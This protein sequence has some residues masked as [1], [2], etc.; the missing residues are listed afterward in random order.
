[1]KHP[2]DQPTIGLI[3]CKKRDRV[4]A[5]YALRDITKPIGLAEWQTKLVKSLPETLNGSLPTI[6]QLEAEFGPEEPS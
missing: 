3:L 2:T 1:M 4:T 5:E 6:E